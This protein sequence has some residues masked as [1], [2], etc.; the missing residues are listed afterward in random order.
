[1]IKI[2]SLVESPER[3]ANLRK[4]IAICLPLQHPNI[5]SV[6]KVMQTKENIYLLMEFISGN[7]CCPVDWYA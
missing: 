1:V 4:E 2:K 6:E 5:L 7:V 3:I